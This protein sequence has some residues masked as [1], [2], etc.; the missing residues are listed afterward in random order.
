M[1]VKS[2]TSFIF[3]FVGDYVIGLEIM[4]VLSLRK[5]MTTIS[6]YVIWEEYETLCLVFSNRNAKLMG[7][8]HPYLQRLLA[9]MNEVSW[10]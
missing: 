7:F 9:E 10:I 3:A 8:F 1:L 5:I 6:K 2:I 4:S